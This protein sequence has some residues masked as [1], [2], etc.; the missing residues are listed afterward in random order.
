[1][2][3]DRR[4]GGGGGVQSHAIPPVTRNLT[5]RTRLRVAPSS[6]QASLHV[7]VRIRPILKAGVRASEA[8]KKDIIRVM[9]NRM[10]VV[11]DPDEQKDYLDQVQGRTKEKKYTFD[12]AFGTASRNCDV[13]D[14]T[15]RELV[16]GCMNGLNVTVFAYGA[17]GSGK[18]YTMVGTKSDPGL[19]VLSLQRIFRDRQ[20]LYADED[21]EVTCSYIE[22][23]NE[24]IYDLLVRNSGPLELRED[25]SLG[26]QVAGIKK[27]TVSSPE[28]IMALLEQGNTRRKTESTN[29]NATSSRSHA[30]LEVNIVRKPRNQ[31]KT[32]TLRGKLSLVDLAGSERAA[33][34]NNAG[35]KLRDG[36]NINRSLLALANC[37]NA[38]GKQGKRGMAYVPYR[39]SKLTRL[40]KD[41]LSGNSKTA[42]IATVS[43]SSDQYNHSI[44]TLKYADRAKEIKTHV[45]KNVG[46]VE[47]HV[48]DYQRIIDNLQTE[49]QQLKDQL[50]QKETL[51]SVTEG[52]S[53]RGAEE[54]EDDQMKWLDDLSSEI[55]ENTEERINLQKA[56]FELED[57]NVLNKCELQQLEHYLQS[58][59]ASEIEA[60]DINERILAMKGNVLENEE[61]GLRYRSDIEAN[62]NQRKA[63]QEK[64]NSAMEKYSSTSFLQVLSTFRMQAVRL[65][66]L[67]FQMAVRDQVISE[68]RDV[69]SNL[70]RVIEGAGLNQH[71]I[72]AIALEQGIVVEGL[73]EGNIPGS[74]QNNRLGGVGAGERNDVPTA[75]TNPTT[76]QQHGRP[77]AGLPLANQ[78]IYGARAQYR[79]DFWQNYDGPG[80][81][82]GQ[83]GEYDEYRASRPSTSQSDHDMRYSSPEPRRRPSDGE[84]DAATALRGSSEQLPSARKTGR[85]SKVGAYSKASPAK[86]V[87]SRRLPPSSVQ[88]GDNQDAEAE[89]S[90]DRDRRRQQPHGPSPTVQHG[91]RQAERNPPPP[92]LSA[93]HSY[94]GPERVRSQTGGSQG[95]QKAQ[96]TIASAWAEEKEPAELFVGPPHAANRDREREPVPTGGAG[97]RLASQL[98]RLKG[99][100]MLRNNAD[101][102]AQQQ[103]V[104]P[105][106]QQQSE[107]DLGALRIEGSTAPHKTEASR[108]T[109]RAR[110][111]SQFD[112]LKGRSSKPVRPAAVTTYE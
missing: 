99:R 1:M 16:L 85:E 14:G 107:T 103:A 63:I 95:N 3:A 61:T 18:T 49:V 13:Y 38:L 82:D 93:E 70:W 57:T 37:I 100:L 79:Y 4:K 21:F 7:A 53:G 102:P 56:L 60:M 29:A 96:K 110:R 97:S 73:T 10:V 58:G 54:S 101:K 17:T 40:L 35:Q 2:V 39:N 108:S 31:Y 11:L 88:P 81:G 43:C 5:S 15:I 91:R 111:A 68:Q 12:V 52:G 50:Q 6:E 47:S 66:E 77:V 86:S 90:G 109:D 78:S 48:S 42:M 98:G 84:R 41:G 32:S 25:P 92:S 69:I 65:Q 45:S 46:T 76:P 106:L 26:V 94:P 23:Y 83:G 30:V 59:H 34:T 33:E 8:D 75:A 51:P 104:P 19:M 55:N 112:R 44:N 105:P 9:N 28:E 80:G 27:H 74:L 89:P 36:A 87:R 72:Q 67:Q 64:I 20:D 24:V 22:V 71:Q 62:E